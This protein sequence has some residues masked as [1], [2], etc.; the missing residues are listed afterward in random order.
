MASHGRRRRPRYD[1]LD[2]EPED[3]I[4]RLR[5][6]SRILAGAEVLQGIGYVFGAPS[7]APSLQLMS[8]RV[9][10][11]V[12]GGLLVIGGLLMLFRQ[13]SIG[14]AICAVVC[15]IWALY[16][17][18]VLVEGTATGWA[19]AWPFGL[20]CAHLYALYRAAR[21]RQVAAAPAAS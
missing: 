10:M 21:A 3:A 14:N 11:P 16:A 1:A 6:H 18:I 17:L 15:L 9:S 5:A 7:T 13:L 20:A 19:W 2:F 8:E 12:W 4:V